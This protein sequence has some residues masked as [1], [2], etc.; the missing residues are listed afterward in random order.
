MYIVM[1]QSFWWCVLPLVVLPAYPLHTKLINQIITIQTTCMGYR[2]RTCWNCCT[3]CVKWILIGPDQATSR[4][5]FNPGQRNYIQTF[6]FCSNWKN[7]WSLN[8]ICNLV[9]LGHFY[10]YSNT[11]T[12]YRI[13]FC[14]LKCE[15][16]NLA[17]VSNS[18][19]SFAVTQ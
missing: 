15:L 13:K 2:G 11:Y 1:Y 6:W 14:L 7:I 16:I 17:G 4:A 10:F 8:V 18:M 3:C 9:R 5:K 19:L 12:G